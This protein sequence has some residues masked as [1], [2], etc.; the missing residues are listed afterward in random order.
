MTDATNP[1]LLPRRKALKRGDDS[2]DPK[3][4]RRLVESL[5]LGDV[6]QLSKNIHTLLTQMNGLD[7]A[8][9][10]RV[11]NLE[12][13]LGPLQFV[14]AAL[15]K[16][17]VREMPPLGKRP[18]LM[19]ETRE[20]LCTLVVQ[21]YKVVL[22][23]YHH[24]SIAGQLLHKSNRALAL[25][26]VL[27]FLGQI[28]L[29][30]YQLYRPAPAFLWREIHGIHRYA[31]DQ[32]LDRRLVENEESDLAPQGS[33]GDL[34]K[35][36]LLLSLAGPQRL[37]QG[38]VS[39][40][41]K[42]L[43]QWSSRT[44]LNDLGRS[45]GGDGHFLV[46]IG[47]DEP[48]RMR[49]AE[50]D[51]QVLKGWILETSE[52]SVHL[53][54][55]L[56]Q[57]EALH[58]VM[59]PR[60]KPDRLSPDLLARLM[61]TWGVGARRVDERDET[62]GEVSLICGLEAIYNAA[63]G[64]ALQKA[65]ASPGAFTASKQSRHSG[66]QKKEQGV[67]RGSLEADEFVIHDDPEL[68]RIRHAIEQ[69]NDPATRSIFLDNPPPVSK[70]PEPA[71]VIRPVLRTCPV[72]NESGGG[73]HLGWTSGQEEQI[74][75]GELVAVASRDPAAKGL[76]RLGVIRWMR[77]ERPDLIDFGVELFSGEITP[78]IFTRQWGRH[79]QKGEWP[80][81]LLQRSEEDPTLITSPF[82]TEPEDKT[83][84]TRGGEK[85]QVMLSREIEAS[86][87]FIQFYCWDPERKNQA[88][89]EIG[90]Y[91]EEDFE[92]LWSHL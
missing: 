58:G 54:S 41:Y 69:S 66:K 35:Q 9:A 24:E 39:H 34:Y 11:A 30:S 44:R 90:E 7:L 59:R 49:G 8:V 15:D 12:A 63:G 26:R 33:V 38:E 80:G 40:V 78:V 77:A 86:A 1:Y 52:L 46:D 81:L 22:D 89:V 71:P 57:T 91:T 6:G 85:R 13:L 27:Y 51:K 50:R 28:L 74:S 61:L 10:S 36:I 37:M 5:P 88:Q 21:A 65:A 62:Q 53:A 70:P 17:F 67:P 16:G 43:A 20:M 32:K 2:F 92:Q 60:E 45:N 25:H 68:M 87:S 31:V 19:A 56:E 76:L 64:E 75:V 14:L 84:I 72:F 55:E 73:Y 4:F 48:P 82:Y 18:A 83:W 29:Q 3:H 79:R 23:Q 47:V 42:A